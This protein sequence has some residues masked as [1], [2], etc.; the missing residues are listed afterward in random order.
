MKAKV[1]RYRLRVL[2]TK[3]QKEISSLESVEELFTIN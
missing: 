1:L 3:S 2:E